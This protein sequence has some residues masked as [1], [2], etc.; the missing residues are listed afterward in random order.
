MARSHFAGDVSEE[1]GIQ[2]RSFQRSEQSSLGHNLTTPIL[3]N[4]ICLFIQLS[5]NCLSKYH[6]YS[7]TET[8]I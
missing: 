8:R 3:R 2:K 6:G 7:R 1:G 5:G 4:S